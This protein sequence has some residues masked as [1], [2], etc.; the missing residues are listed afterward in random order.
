VVDLIPVPHNAAAYEDPKRKLLLLKRWLFSMLATKET[1]MLVT[2]LGVS[3]L[4]SGL[5]TLLTLFYSNGRKRRRLETLAVTKS[6][7][8]PFKCIGEWKFYNNGIKLRFMVSFTPWPL[9]SYR[10]SSQVRIGWWR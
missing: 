6:Y 2:A 9:Y 1:V 5:A 7:F 3:L 4:I 10:K 8:C